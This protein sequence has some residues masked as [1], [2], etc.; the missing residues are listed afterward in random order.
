MAEPS[1]I[2]DIINQHSCLEAN[3][4]LVRLMSKCDETAQFPPASI[5]YDVEAFV[6]E[7][8]LNYYGAS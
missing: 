6:I 3:Y 4:S 8:I 2:R 7:I 5:V 1:P